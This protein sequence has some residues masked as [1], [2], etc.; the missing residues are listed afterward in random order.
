MSYY[1]WEFTEPGMKDF[2]IL[3]HSEVYEEDD[4]SKE[5]LT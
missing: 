4:W 2:N 5:S 3:T 1:D